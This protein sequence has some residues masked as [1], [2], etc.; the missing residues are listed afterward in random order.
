MLHRIFS[1]KKRVV[2]LLLFLLLYMGFY[3]F[4]GREVLLQTRDRIKRLQGK[5]QEVK[6]YYDPLGAQV[7]YVEKTAGDVEAIHRQRYQAL[8]E[9]VTFQQGDRYRIP[10]DERSPKNYFRKIVIQFKERLQEYPVLF[11]PHPLQDL[12]PEGMKTILAKMA[13]ADRAAETLKEAGIA[14]ATFSDIQFQS[15]EISD[16]PFIKR[17][18]RS[19]LTITGEAPFE[20]TV[21]WIASLKRPGRFFFLE[22]IALSRL[23]EAVSFRADLTTIQPE[24]KERLSFAPVAV[25]QNSDNDD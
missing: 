23:G 2:L 19:R 8:L 16:D 3:I 20:K 22:Q 18:N 5:V 9:K 25:L 17:L 10:S 24:I 13:L 4:F 14:H 11:L 1:E 12:D 7:Q 15:V 6:S 21:K